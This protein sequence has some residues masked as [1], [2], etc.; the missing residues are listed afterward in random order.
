MQSLFSKLN[1]LVVI[2]KNCNLPLFIILVHFPLALSTL[3][4]RD[5][6]Q[7]TL[8]RCPGHH[9]VQQSLQDQGMAQFALGSRA[10]S[11]GS[12]T[13]C[14]ST[15]PVLSKEFHLFATPSKS[16]HQ[17]ALKN[18][19]RRLKYQKKSQAKSP[20][21][22]GGCHSLAPPREVTWV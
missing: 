1:I 9:I 19:F 14:L 4:V 8:D 17:L 11:P 7:S 21:V 3:M 13:V 18:T 2:Q 16:K 5:T 12:V 15:N 20:N 6:K 10:A 22:G